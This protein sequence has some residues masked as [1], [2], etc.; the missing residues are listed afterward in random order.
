MVN[1]AASFADLILDYAGRAMNIGDM[2]KVLKHLRRDPVV[3]VGTHQCH[4]FILVCI[5]IVALYSMLVT[6]L[7]ALCISLLLASGQSLWYA[8][9]Y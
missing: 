3:K 4:A 7:V 9:L 8:E 5:C 2:A 1:S 6:A